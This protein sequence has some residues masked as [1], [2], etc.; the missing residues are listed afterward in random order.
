M[1]LGTLVEVALPAKDATEERF[2]AAFA[3]ISHVHRTMSAHDSASDLARIAGGAHR[4]AVVVD[5]GTMAVLRLARMLHR[6]TVGAFDV[7]VAPVLARGG[8]LPARAASQ[9]AGVRNMAEVELLPGHQVRTSKPTSLDLGGIAKGYA[10]DCAVAA[11]RVAGTH[12][13]IVNAGGDWRAFGA[14]EWHSLRVRHPMH[15]TRVVTL[16]QVCNASSATSADYFGDARGHLVEPYTGALR[17]F[18]GS[19][20][21][22][23]HSCALADALTKVVALAP[24]TSHKILSRFGAHAFRLEARD[25][26]LLAATTCTT[27][28]AHLRLAPRLA[29]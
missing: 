27:A 2:A 22:V 14:H 4:H 15:P 21:V 7:A 29:A 18:G 20:T 8:L 17:R 6:A 23:A 24:D 9:S 1:W 28:T 11:L 25:D 26:A 16:A 5:A 19:I 13:G 3:A 10:V 12:A